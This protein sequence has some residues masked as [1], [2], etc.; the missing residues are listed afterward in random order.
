MLLQEHCGNVADK[1]IEYELVIVLMDIVL[2]RVTA[3]RHIY[4]NRQD[5]WT[6]HV[7]F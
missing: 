7:C 3:F 1:Y 6:T 4:R 5:L 2:H